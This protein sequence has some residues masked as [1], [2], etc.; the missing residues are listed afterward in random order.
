MRALRLAAL[1]LV[2]VLCMAMAG[3]VWLA[4][5][6]SGSR[7]LVQQS[8]A[9]SPV[10]VA[11][12][13][14]TGS[15]G[16]GLHARSLAI[17]LE[18]G[19]LQ[20][21]DVLVSMSPAALLAGVILLDAVAIGE[22][23]L[24][25]DQEAARD[26]L[27]PGK[28]VLGWLDL[29]VTVRVESGQIDIFRVD[30]VTISDVELAGQI[31]HGKMQLDR[32][33]ASAADVRVDMTGQL[34][35]PAP[36]K[37]KADVQWVSADNGLAGQ[38]LV[39]GDLNRLRVTHEARVP[40]ELYFAGEL[41]DL[42]AAP[43][44]QGELV[45]E[46]WALPGTPE[47]IVRG[48]LVAVSADLATLRA[49]ARGVAELEVPESLAVPVPLTFDAAIDTRQLTLNHLEASVL[50]G[51]LLGSG[52]LSFAE[53]LAGEFVVQADGLDMAA[54]DSGLEGT[55]AFDGAINIE[56]ASA[57]DLQ[58]STLNGTLAGHPFAGAGQLSVRDGRLDTLDASVQAGENILRVESLGLGE[59]LAG[60]ISADVP[61]LNYLWPEIAGVMNL[62]ASLAGTRSSPELEVDAQVQGLSSEHY[63]L[64]SMKL[65]GSIG[66]GEE[67]N[68]SARAT[69]VVVNDLELGAAQADVGGSLQDHEVSFSLK[70]EP[71]K[72]QLNLAGSWDGA[73]LRQMVTNGIVQLKGS[74]AWYLQDNPVLTLATG[75]VQ[76]DAHCWEQPD[77]RERSS[78]CLGEGR[79][80]ESGVSGSVNLQRVSL[81]DFNVLLADG[82]S[83]RGVV[84]AEAAFTARDDAV[85]GY[86]DW[87][88][89]D[90]E[91]RFQD[92]L[93]EFRTRLDDI[94]LR[95]DI[96]PEVT[97]ATGSI[98]GDGGL[99]LDVAGTVSGPLAPESPLQ[100]RVDGQVPDIELFRPLLRRVLYPGR[101][102]GAVS[103][104]L[105]IAG[106]LGQPLFSGGAQLR[107]GEI[108]LVDAGITLE[109][110]Q[111]VA[112]SAGKDTLAVNGS[113]RSGNGRAEVTGEI[114]TSD[115][116]ALQGVL[117][118]QGKNMATLRVP[119]LTADTSPD[120]TIRIGPELFDVS[121]VLVIPQAS[122]KINQVGDT[123]IPR[124]TDVVVHR[125]N[126]E[127]ELQNSTIV[128]GDLRIELGPQVRFE[129]FGLVSRLTGGLRLT[130]KKG[131]FLR[132]NGTVRV[133]D[134]YLNG[135][136]KELRVDRGELTFTGLLDD[137]AINIQVSRESDYEGR[138]Y[139]IGL[140][141]TGTAR[142][143][144][145][146][147]F[148]RP[149][150]PEQDILSFLLLDRPTGSDADVGGAALAL[151]LKQV[152]PGDKGGTTLG[153]D[154]IGLEGTELDQTAVV[155][156]KRI[157]DDLYVR[158][159]FGLFG[160]PGS[161]RIR[162]RLGRG[163]S[164]EASTGAN[165]ALD[166][167]YLIEK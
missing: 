115:A 38:G 161:F 73:E 131:S 67:L 85:H 61:D 43:S 50:S 47:T 46:Q 93:D 33:S 20:A 59:Q 76:L 12:T 39:Q 41:V 92:D 4:G 125:E 142:K 80:A 143:V 102:A 96:E 124:S 97:R 148:S 104:D 55:L 117:Q 155:A 53:D 48:G 42:L 91:L 159:V 129:G 156:G 110:I 138:R 150:L 34:E 57:I 7:W 75:S 86:V 87:R 127:E 58:V 44:L 31:G 151:G 6:E 70:G 26:E 10:P 158:Y 89:A 166:L 153:L 98:R 147:P 74:P 28:D 79:Y 116:G 111:L 9:L 119:D 63:A 145:T 72:G 22:L 77:G 52:R 11:V 137:P 8:V 3:L 81:A 128:T 35:G 120:L 121:G 17:D 69:G 112:E 95:V 83:A 106:T 103:I 140:R 19:Q 141:L 94:Q 133:K 164:L 152:M 136:G 100:G 15:L 71:A 13:D 25:L 36:G 62:R 157:S 45:W 146:T 90:T 78:V 21:N 68:G 113:L 144:I 23:E 123:A 24:Q 5:S 165:Q 134:G 154:E 49:T 135:Y 160:E 101:M 162:Y 82:F 126:V 30:A 14:I 84:D 132:A 105:A 54:Y 66:R 163:F 16:S 114:G 56:S 107:D 118:V 60:H 122:A 64:D 2:L 1:G 51:Q 29:P 65:V 37:L 40:E 27:A 139:T 109:D 88:Q 32:L 130:Q 167:I 18:Q 149:M 108:E 99:Q